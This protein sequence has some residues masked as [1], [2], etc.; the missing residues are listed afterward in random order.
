MVEDNPGDV[1]LVRY[2]LEAQEVVY[3]L[4]VIPDG[5]VALHFF[6]ELAQQAHL[7]CPDVVLL[8]LNLPR[9]D[10]LEVLRRVKAIPQCAQ[11][12]IVIFSTGLTAAVGAAIRALGALHCF[13][14]P[15]TPEELQEVIT[16]VTA[17][18]HARRATGE[19]SHPRPS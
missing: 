17:M 16:L 10:G 18:A 15:Y 3:T 6:T 7:P 1:A 5:E 13:P 14:K 11:V 4:Q 19:S 2:A 8:D 9:V 12:L